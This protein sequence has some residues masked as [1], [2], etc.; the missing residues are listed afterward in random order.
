M[1]A[2][3]FSSILIAFPFFLVSGPFLT[4]L[5]VVLIG[6]YYIASLN[7]IEARMLL[8]NNI[9]KLVIAFWFYAIFCSLF[10]SNISESL[11]SS[12]FYGRF[13]LFSLGTAFIINQNKKVLLYFGVSLWVCLI[14]LTLD[15][16]LQFFSGTA[17]QYWK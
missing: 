14:I 7:R 8:K 3:T 4:N 10:S 1:A 9:V 17:C 12:L 16:Y 11:G 5:S 6:F 13:I 15:G 2:K